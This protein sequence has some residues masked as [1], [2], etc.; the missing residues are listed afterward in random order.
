MRL[1]GGLH[2]VESLQPSQGDLTLEVIFAL[3]TNLNGC[4]DLVDALIRTAFGIVNR[5]KSQKTTT[6]LVI[7]SVNAI[8]SLDAGEALN[9]S[10]IM[11]LMPSCS[12]GV[13]MTSL[14]VP[15]SKIGAPLAC[16]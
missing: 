3:Q 8:I 7:P 10:Q 4:L 9:L 11:L 1:L 16:R 13:R 6:R 12:W 15:T 5:E 2:G 14:C